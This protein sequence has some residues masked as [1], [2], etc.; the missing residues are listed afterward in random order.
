MAAVSAAAEAQQARA[1]RASKMDEDDAEGPVP[2]IPTREERKPLTTA[3]SPQPAASPAPSGGSGGGGGGGMLG[4][5]NFAQTRLQRLFARQSELVVKHPGRMIW[6]ALI[7]VNLA[8]PAALLGY[9]ELR[10]EQ[11]VLPQDAREIEAMEAIDRNFGHE[12]GFAA[13][14]FRVSDA[15]V[16]RAS[17]TCAPSSHRLPLSCMSARVLPT[18]GRWQQRHSQRREHQ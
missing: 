4:C 5:S 7:W 16:A 8:V 10:N 6:G 1:A 9:A 15:A 14:V 11:T 17:R 12:E 3:A 2:M 13:V 18:A